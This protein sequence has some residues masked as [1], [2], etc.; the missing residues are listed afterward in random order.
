[1][2]NADKYTQLKVVTRRLLGQCEV[3]KNMLDAELADRPSTATN[4]YS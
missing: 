1:M 3:A 4:A 2:I